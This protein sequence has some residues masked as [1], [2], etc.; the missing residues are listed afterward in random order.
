MTDEPV[1]VQMTAAQLEAAAFINT[2]RRSSGVSMCS[3]L[4]W[5]DSICE[6][7]VVFYG[8]EQKSKIRKSPGNLRSLLPWD[9]TRA[10]SQS[11]LPSGRLNC[12]PMHSA[13]ELCRRLP[14]LQHKQVSFSTW[15]VFKFPKRS[16]F[17]RGV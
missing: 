4:R 2:A 7:V 14:S 6:V 3:C 11:S 17:L 10:M 1:C 8:K 16:H 12:T 13:D 9:A 5:K 15:L